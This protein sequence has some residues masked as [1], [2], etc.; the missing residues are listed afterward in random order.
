MIGVVAN[1]SECAVV[2]EFFELFKTPWEVYRS[3]REYDVLLSAGDGPLQKGAAPLV[4]IYSGRKLSYDADHGM[5]TASHKGPRM[6]S[7]RGTQLPIY[8]DC[9]IFPTSDSGLLVGRDS[10]Q[11]A[12]YLEQSKGSTL[13]RI[14][15]DLF[16]EV[17]IL[18]TAGQPPNNAGIPTLELHITI[19]RDLIVASGVP[20]MEIPPVPQ[21][22]DFIACLTHDVDHPSI[23]K[24]KFDHTMLG[25][26]Y[27]AI[28]GSLVSLFRGRGSIR[29]LL[30]NWAAALKLPFVHL[31][32]A[33]DFWYEFER[34]PALE[35]G[36]PSSFFVIPFKGRPGCS[37][38]GPAPSRRA[39][40][41]SA[42]EITACI[43]TLMCAGCEI[44]LHGI[45][46]WV[47]TSKGREEL[48][49]IRRITGSK[50]IGARM[51]W[52]YF[53]EQSAVK[54]EKAGADYDSTVGY[55]ETVGYR[56][57]TTQA[58][59]PLE[60]TQLLELPL[61]VMDTALFYPC[62]LDLS[63]PEASERVASIIDNAIRFGGSVIVN[64]HDRSIAPERLWGDFY[65]QLVEEL[66]NRGAWFA[67]A[68]DTVA[69]FRK[70][71]SATFN[72]SNRGSVSLH[73][74]P[75]LAGL[76]LPALRLRSY[77]WDA[78]E[79]GVSELPKL[80]QP[81]CGDEVVSLC[82]S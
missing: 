67:T 41:Y 37:E 46:A 6:L 44:G 48:E 42:S 54:L 73:I 43:H 49:E 8:G 17:S 51:H 3:D 82:R 58:Y 40:R 15:Y 2:R 10:G 31:G 21:G 59:K 79:G 76:T 20:L 47:D 65:G 11:P 63:P 72:A 30:D 25:F 53:G 39:S 74:D 64:W 33:R 27:R 62:Y 23:R 22:Y 50:D 24:H 81:P 66:K 68:A 60:A 1:S 32:L 36:V 77:N 45:D 75:A 71:R 70:R 14:G 56:A 80:S 28:F 5:H 13:A 38:R 9:V 4:L 35:S 12:I 57:G 78:I 61:H 55:N 34:Y 69:W 26:L 18:L 29:G 52:L 16:R 7:H 19:L